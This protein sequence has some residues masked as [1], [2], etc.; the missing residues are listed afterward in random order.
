MSE[1]QTRVSRITIARLHNC[2]NYEHVRYEISVDVAPSANPASIAEELEGLLEDLKPQRTDYD[3]EL[4]NA[5]T[6]LAKSANELSAMEITNLPV[7]RERVRKADE[8]FQQRQRGY[9]R[10]NALGGSRVY[11]DAKEKW[12]DEDRY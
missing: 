7:Y 3:Y 1:E 4:V 12:D 6:I 8:S 11:T 9:E 2:G 5:R 10:L